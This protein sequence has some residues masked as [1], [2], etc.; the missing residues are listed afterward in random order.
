VAV[1]GEARNQI[2]LGVYDSLLKSS[3]IRECKRAGIT[4]R[5]ILWVWRTE[6]TGVLADR[7]QRVGHVG[8]ETYSKL[9]MNL[10]HVTLTR[11]LAVIKEWFFY[12]FYAILAGGYLGP[13]PICVPPM[14]HD[15]EACALL[16]KRKKP[17]QDPSVSE[18][19]VREIRMFL[20][21]GVPGMQALAGA[22][23]AIKIRFHPDDSQGWVD[24][25]NAAFAGYGRDIQRRLEEC[26]WELHRLDPCEL[27]L[28]Y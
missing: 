19:C 2:A 28:L 3:W 20:R 23:Q 16:R 12:L 9:W 10:G 26:E 15:D 22:W 8:R 27:W 17:P 7:N 11:A 4:G 5:E 1:S 18:E 21:L 6:T 24:S 25:C 14:M 13:S